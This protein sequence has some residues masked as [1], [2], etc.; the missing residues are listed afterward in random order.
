MELDYPNQID[1]VQQISQF[2]LCRLA[3]TDWKIPENTFSLSINQQIGLGPIALN[4]YIKTTDE[5]ICNRG[6]ST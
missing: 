5:E 1:P 4:A 2:F 3:A 6:A